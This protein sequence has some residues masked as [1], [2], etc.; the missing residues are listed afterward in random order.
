MQKYNIQCL[1]KNANKL[2]VILNITIVL[3]PSI[4]CH[5]SDYYRPDCVNIFFSMTFG[6]NLT[7]PPE[8]LR[9]S[10]SISQDRMT[11]SAR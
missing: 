7:P 10:V 2:A 5:S 9:Q 3:Y 6:F 11:Y 8:I 4:K 1:Q